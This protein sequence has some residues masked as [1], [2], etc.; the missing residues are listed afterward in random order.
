MEAL[1]L[2]ALAVQANNRLA[3]MAEE[4]VL[5]ELL[6]ELSLADPARAEVQ[7]LIP[8]PIM[9]PA[10]VETPMPTIAPSD[11]VERMQAAIAMIEPPAEETVTMSLRRMPDGSLQGS[12]H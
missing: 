3:E 11:I 12:V 1:I 10:K 6:L 9:F 7:C 8:A 5:V 2:Q 4:S